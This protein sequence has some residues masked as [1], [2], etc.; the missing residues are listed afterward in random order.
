[1]PPK[2]APR[3]VLQWEDSFVVMLLSVDPGGHVSAD[4]L[5]GFPAVD[6]T[7]SPVAPGGDQDRF[8]VNVDNSLLVLRPDGTTFVHAVKRQPGGSVGIGPF[9][10][11]PPKATTGA[12]IDVRPDQAKFVGRMMDRRLFVVHPDGGTLGYDVVPDGDDAFVHP[13]FA[14]GGAR[15]AT[16]DGVRYVVGLNFQIVLI[17]S[18]GSVTGYDTDTSNNLLPPVTFTGPKIDLSPDGDDFVVT[19]GTSNSF[20]PG[21]QFSAVVVHSDGSVVGHSLAH[22]TVSAPFAVPMGAPA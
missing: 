6:V 18:D 8:V 15:I 7:G 3:F 2:A 13:P 14:F 5:E 22:H 19:M 11:H 12:P 4:F 16:D 17:R 21:P 9:E 1:M 10:I 20:T